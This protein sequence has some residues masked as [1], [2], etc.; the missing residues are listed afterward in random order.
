MTPQMAMQHEVLPTVRVD[1]STCSMRCC[2]EIGGVNLE[3]L[4]HAVLDCSMRCCREIGGVNLAKLTLLVA[5][6]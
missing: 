4:Q 3:I 1:K 6:K 2:K 5:S